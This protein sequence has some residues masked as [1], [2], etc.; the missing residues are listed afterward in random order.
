MKYSL[1]PRNKGLPPDS[2]SGPPAPGH[3]LGPG[4]HSSFHVEDLLT[5][6]W[7]DPIGQKLA[8]HL[9]LLSSMVLALSLWETFKTVFPEGFWDD[10]RRQR[11]SRIWHLGDL[12][13]IMPSTHQRP[14]L[15][16]LRSQLSGKWS[17]P[18]IFKPP[19]PHSRQTQ[20]MGTIWSE[21]M[22]II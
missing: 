6:P 17:G 21:N 20:C 13:S 18:P 15:V 3:E 12:G 5:R 10:Y 9:H 11:M 4:I 8:S 7:S 2:N 14:G 19:N 1:K 16:W 22:N